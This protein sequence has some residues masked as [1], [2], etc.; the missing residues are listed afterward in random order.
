MSK[1]RKIDF[2]LQ[3]NDWY[4]TIFRFY[5]R[6]SS[7]HSFGDEPPKDWNDVYKTYYS[8][9]I[10]ERWKDDNEHM[11]LYNSRCDECSIIDEVAARCKCLAKGE[12]EPTISY[13][14]KTWTVKI[15][16]NEMYP[17]GDGTSW[18][19][20]ESRNYYKFHLFRYDDVGFR[21]WLEKERIGEFGEYLESCCEYMLAHGDPI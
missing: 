15:L 6:Q 18:T 3:D 19:I 5:P 21:F 10:F 4:T 8:Y 13:N 7:C 14:D 9:S 16:D 20:S 17:M 11:I 1:K 12:T 2:V